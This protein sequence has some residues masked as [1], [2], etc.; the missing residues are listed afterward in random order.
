MTAGIGSGRSAR[1]Q[2][3]RVE[4]IE[5]L[6]PP[7]TSSALSTAVEDIQCAL[8]AGVAVVASAGEP[9]AGSAEERST[10]TLGV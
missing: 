8:A 5:R 9:A 6:L 3:E 1:E 10:E 7:W 2:V 4:P